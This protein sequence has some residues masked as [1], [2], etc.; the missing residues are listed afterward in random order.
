MLS[1]EQGGADNEKRRQRMESFLTNGITN[2]YTQAE[3][4]ELCIDA[5]MNAAEKT[6]ENCQA[7]APPVEKDATINALQEERDQFKDALEQQLLTYKELQDKQMAL[8][9]KHIVLHN[10]H[11]KLKTNVQDVVELNKAYCGTLKSAL[12]DSDSDS[13]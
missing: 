2:L 4:D 10:A 6:Y 13:N 7:V 9:N 11:K 12:E 8:L 5:S 3:V 1:N